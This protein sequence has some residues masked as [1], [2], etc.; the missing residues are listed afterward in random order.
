MSFKREKVK[1]EKPLLPPNPVSVINSSY[2]ANL[3]QCDPA[4]EFPSSFSKAI[5]TKELHP[6]KFFAQA[7]TKGV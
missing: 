3:S 2:I 5:P 1:P 7:V 4:T 6:K